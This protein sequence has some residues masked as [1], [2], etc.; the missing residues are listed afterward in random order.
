MNLINSTLIHRI[1]LPRKGTSGKA[2]VLIMLH[3]RGAD[4]NDLI[5]LSEY[6]DE[7]LFII[8]VQAPFQFAYTGGFTWFDIEDIGKPDLKMFNES[9]KKLLKFID[10]VKSGYPIDPDKIFLFGFSMGTMMAYA[11]SLTHPEMIRGVIANSGIIPEGLDLDYKWEKVKE[12]PYFV[13]HGVHDSIIPVAFAKRA[14][15]LL[16]KSEAQVTYREYEMD[17]QIDEESLADIMKW[18]ERYI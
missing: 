18:L 16:E 1:L 14:K 17:H 12:R 5:G 7:R 9:Y 10:D 4:E 8:S 15:V 2:P 3:G 13:S 6:L 11:V